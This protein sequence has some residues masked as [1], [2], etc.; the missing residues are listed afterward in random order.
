ML[1]LQHHDVQL[2]TEKKQKKTHSHTET[3]RLVAGV[4]PSVQRYQ[5]VVIDDYKF[6]RRKGLSVSVK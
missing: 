5:Y 6:E 3:S 1:S 2:N 4:K